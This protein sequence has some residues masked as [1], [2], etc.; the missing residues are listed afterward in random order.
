LSVVG[1][2]FEVFSFQ[3]SG[4]ELNTLFFGLFTFGVGLPTFS[5]RSAR[6]SRPRRNA[7]PQGLLFFA[8]SFFASWLTIDD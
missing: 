5:L 6:V 3:F 1:E 4:W 7:R 8:S 2:E